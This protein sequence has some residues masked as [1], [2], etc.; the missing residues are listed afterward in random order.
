MGL[1]RHGTV[2]EEYRVLIASSIYPPQIGGPAVQAELFARKLSRRGVDVRV[3]TYGP[4]PKAMCDVRVEYLD[5]TGGRGPVAA[6]RRHFRIARQVSRLFRE[7]RPHA[8]Q[9]QTAGGL[10]PL[11]VGI[12][13]RFCG[14]PSWVKFAG[15]PV[16][17]TVSR[18]QSSGA[19]ED[20]KRWRSHV[21]VAVA[22]LFARL[23]F[24][25]Y[26]F[27]WVT[28]PAIAEELSSR[29]AIS[30]DRI[31]IEPNLVEFGDRPADR[32]PRTAGGL[33]TPLR[34]LMVTRLDPIK[35]VDVAIRALAQ[36][37]GCSAVLRVV[38]EGQ[39]RYVDHL[40]SI[41]EE[42]GVSDRIEWA[43]PVAREKLSEEYRSADL[44]IVPSHYETFGVV[45]V[46][47]M[48]AGL[49]VIAS[50]VGGVSNVVDGGR[51]ARLVEPGDPAALAR[52][53]A[54]LAGDPDE[55]ARLSRQGPGR[56]TQFDAEA[57]VERWLEIYRASGSAKDY[58][59]VRSGM[60]KD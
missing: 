28:T 41:A 23:V 50:N 43:G 1:K 27:V 16:L 42:L 34:L 14:I 10:F 4:P 56:A 35:G 19:D 39:P 5:H 33:A 18:Q 45:I 25:T 48:A 20:A 8:V 22:K 49:P 38:G 30:R 15:D 32:R 55:M 57:G 46:E 31:V 3:L 24:R 17:E 54:E 60:V 58:P 11:T 36:V 29:W 44:L 51:Y 6:S 7:F 13:A 12:I 26:R 2:S 52:G 21:R 53:I 59:L 40:R 37:S 9:M 47:A